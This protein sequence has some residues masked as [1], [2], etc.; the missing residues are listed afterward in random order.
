MITGKKGEMMQE[1]NLEQL[2]D[3]LLKN[4]GADELDY[5]H[6]VMDMYNLFTKRWMKMR[7]S[8]KLICY[9]ILS[10]RELEKDVNELINEKLDYV[11]KD[12][13]KGINELKN[14]TKGD[15]RV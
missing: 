1:F 11:R 7:F 6:G 9:I 15:F 13:I 4:V 3:E 12:L 14:N 8:K 10:E 2:R 5:I